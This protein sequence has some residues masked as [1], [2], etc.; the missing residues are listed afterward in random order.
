[1]SRSYF[2]DNFNAVGVDFYDVALVFVI[3][4]LGICMCLGLPGSDYTQVI[5][6][7]FESTNC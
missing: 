7:S 6:C 5:K 3:V 2:G 4:V 1:M